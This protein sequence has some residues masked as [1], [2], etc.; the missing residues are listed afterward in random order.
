[1]NN[2]GTITNVYAGMTDFVHRGFRER[3]GT[4]DD[5]TVETALASGEGPFEKTTLWQYLND[6]GLKTYCCVRSQ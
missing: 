5:I 6:R 4:V 2:P 3:W 1:M